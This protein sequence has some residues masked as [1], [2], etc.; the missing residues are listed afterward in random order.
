MFRED[1]RCASWEEGAICRTMTKKI[2]VVAAAEEVAE[3]TQAVPVLVQSILKEEVMHRAQV[4]AL[5]LH[6][7]CCD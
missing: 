6:S 1:R 5:A 2:E 7:Y 4:M 3:D